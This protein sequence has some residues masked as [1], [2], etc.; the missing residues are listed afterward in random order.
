MELEKTLLQDLT[1]LGFTDPFEPWL[2]TMDRLDILPDTQVKV[3]EETGK[4]I[5]IVRGQTRLKHIAYLLIEVDV[6]QTYYAGVIFHG[7]LFGDN[8]EPLPEVIIE[9]LSKF[10]TSSVDQEEYDPARLAVQDFWFLCREIID[11]AE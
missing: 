8:C 10:L 4:F 3:S 6:R 5:V 2:F 7:K 11:L 9:A 1:G